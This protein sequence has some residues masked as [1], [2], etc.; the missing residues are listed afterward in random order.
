MLTDQ[1]GTEVVLLLVTNESVGVESYGEGRVGMVPDVA[2]DLP[3]DVLRRSWVRCT[4]STGTANLDTV[5][6]IGRHERDGDR[7]TLCHVEVSLGHLVLVGGGGGTQECHRGVVVG[8]RARPARWF[9]VDGR[10]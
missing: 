2:A 9:P 1:V 5:G 6:I 4:A 3:V 10:K 7:V 8:A